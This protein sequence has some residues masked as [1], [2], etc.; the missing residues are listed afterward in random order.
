MET[1][2]GLAVLRHLE[3]HVR[4]LEADEFHLRGGGLRAAPDREADESAREDKDDEEPGEF[5]L[6]ITLGIWDL[7]N[8]QLPRKNPPWTPSWKKLSPH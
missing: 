2:V 8:R 4:F 6:L 7:F 1:H 3:R 5:H